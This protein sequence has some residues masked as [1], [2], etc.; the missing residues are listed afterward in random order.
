MP[1]SHIHLLMV[2]IPVSHPPLRMVN[3]S[4]PQDVFWLMP[5]SMPHA[6]L[7]SILIHMLVAIRQMIARHCPHVIVAFAVPFRLHERC[8]SLICQETPLLSPHHRWAAACLGALAPL[9]S[10]CGTRRPKLDEFKKKKKKK[11]KRKSLF[12]KKVENCVKDIDERN[13]VGF[14]KPSKFIA[15]CA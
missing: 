7:C 5:T 9:L 6:S 3:I 15:D 10:M 13:W 4:W 14:L 11:V 12:K 2:E 1:V 8:C